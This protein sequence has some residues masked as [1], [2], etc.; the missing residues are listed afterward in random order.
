MIHLCEH[1]KDYIEQKLLNGST[2]ECDWFDLRLSVKHQNM[3][4]AETLKRVNID[5][6]FNSEHSLDVHGKKQC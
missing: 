6:F 2:R 3:I 1:E 4:A 5:H